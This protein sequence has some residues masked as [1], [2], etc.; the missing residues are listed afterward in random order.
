MREDGVVWALVV[1]V[2]PEELLVVITAAVVSV[3]VKIEV[4]RKIEEMIKSRSSG[5]N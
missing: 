4:M 3:K 5:K 2:V 1:S